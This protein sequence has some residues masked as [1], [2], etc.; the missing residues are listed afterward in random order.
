[1]G[2]GT[3]SSKTEADLLG[4]RK[5]ES[6]AHQRRVSCEPDSHPLDAPSLLAGLSDPGGD[7]YQCAGLRPSFS[8]RN[9]ALV[10]LAIH[11]GLVRPCSEEILE[12]AIPLRMKT[13]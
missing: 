2:D 4:N 1:M 7:R 10:L 9:E 8:R 5:F 3:A 13:L 11:Q 6:I 12:G